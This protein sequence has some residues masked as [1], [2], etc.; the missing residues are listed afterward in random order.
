MLRSRIIPCLLI[1]KKGLVKTI[2]F[3]DPKYIGD[4]INAVKIFN[5]KK[6]DELLLLDI[7]AS[8][9]NVKPDFKKLKII[10]NESR[11]PLTYGGGISTV[12]DARRIISLGFEKISISHSALNNINLIEQIANEIGSQSVVFCLDYKR[13]FITQK[14][15]IFSLNGKS[16]HKIN[17][18][19]IAKEAERLGAGEIVFNSI[20]RDGTLKGYDIDFAQKIRNHISTQISFM[21]GACSMENMEE[22]LDKVGIV[23]LVAGSMFVFKG[24]FRAVLLSYERPKMIRNNIND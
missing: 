13:N 5:E 3:G 20:D 24:K 14:N 22:I 19:E 9:N 18:F 21:G 4:P 1:S 15:T 7:D 11:M 10:A 12:E 17:I 23:G 6:V 2:N 8:R 16:K